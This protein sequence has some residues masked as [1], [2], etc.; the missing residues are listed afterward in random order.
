MFI[1]TA[2]VLLVVGAVAY[3]YSELRGGASGRRSVKINK[4]KREGA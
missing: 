1:V 4:S 3:A 2:G